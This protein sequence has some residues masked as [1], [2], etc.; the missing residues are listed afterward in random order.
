MDGV[1]VGSGDWRV[2]RVVPAA[3]AAPGAVMAEHAG[4]PHP[5]E[6]EFYFTRGIYSSGGGGNDDWGARWAVDYPKA[7]HQFLI[8]V[9]RLT[10][11]DAYPAPALLVRVGGRGLFEVLRE[12]LRWGER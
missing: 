10:A 8:A 2:V 6:H 3:L 11:I 4:N 9:K 12:K 1:G 7:D 5:L